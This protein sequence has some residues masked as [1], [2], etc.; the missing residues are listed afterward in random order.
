MKAAM[1]CLHPK[2]AHSLAPLSKNDANSFS[3]AKFRKAD[4]P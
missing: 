1:R 2:G 3:P 4:G